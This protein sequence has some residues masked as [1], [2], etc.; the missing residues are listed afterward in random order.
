MEKGFTQE[1]QIREIIEH[2]KELQKILQLISVEAIW[3]NLQMSTS[4]F[5]ST[6]K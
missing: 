3:E 1:S 6:Q 2:V 4:S 5:S